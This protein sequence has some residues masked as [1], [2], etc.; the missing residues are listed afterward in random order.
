MFICLFVYKKQNLRVWCYHRG[1]RKGCSS[2]LLR[3]VE[4]TGKLVEEQIGVAGAHSAG[5]HGCDTGT[6]ESVSFSCHWTPAIGCII[7][8]H[9]GSGVTGHKL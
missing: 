8:A 4:W 2:F 6:I 1:G 7:V 9:G 3:A 5:G